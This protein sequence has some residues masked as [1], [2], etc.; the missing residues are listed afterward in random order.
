MNRDF[1]Q[2]YVSRSLNHFKQGMKEKWNLKNY[3]NP[4]KPSIFL[5]IYNNEDL[6]FALNHQSYGIVIYGGNDLNPKRVKKLFSIKKNTFFTFGYAWIADFF[7][8]HNIKYKQMILPIKKF[9]DLKPT[10]LGKNIYVYIGQPNNKRYEYF[11][12]DEVIIP[13]IENFGENRVIWVKGNSHVNFKSLVENYYN[14]CF[15]FVKPNI[16]GGSTTMW[17][18]AHM[19]RKTI[20]Q[21]QGGA[22]NVLEYRDLNHMIDLIYEESK[23]I[24]TVQNEV[25]DSIKEIFQ[26][27]D[28]W[29]KLNF[30]K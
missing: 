12:F 9:D 13:L 21:N 20:A 4:N 15:I 6:Q 19:G 7:I 26:N 5:G 29:L 8:K 27:N 25:H 3:S 30:W 28:D 24:G 1:N 16:R 2:L 22:T 23:K 11:K 14:D 10:K 17:E 18:L